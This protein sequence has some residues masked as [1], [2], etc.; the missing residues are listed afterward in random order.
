MGISFI[1][2]A[3]IHLGSPLVASSEEKQK[4][5]NSAIEESLN[6][7]VE[8][9]IDNSVDFVVIAGD[10]FD[11]SITN[12]SLA[13][14]FIKIMQPLTNHKIPSY[15]IWGNHDAEGKHNL[16]FSDSEYIHFFKASSPH[17]FLINEKHIALHGQSFASQVVKEN[18]AIN[19]P[20]KIEGA[21]NIGVL[22]TSLDGR[23]GH[24]TYAPCSLQDLKNKEYD[25]WALGHIHKREI[26]NDHR[27]TV[28]YSGNLQGR[29]IKEDNDKGCYLVNI[30]EKHNVDA[31]FIPISK[32]IFLREEINLEN[33]KNKDEVIQLVRE[34][35]ALNS[36]PAYLRLTF[37]GK[38]I[39]SSSL[40]NNNMIETLRFELL[41][42]NIT[43]MKIKNAT[44]YPKTIDEVRQGKN[45]IGNMLSLLSDETTKKETL[46]IVSEELSLF[47]GISDYLPDED[48]LYFRLKENSEET[49]E[50]LIV[51]QLQKDLV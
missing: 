31:Q 28:I 3:D 45:T 4:E 49:I 43:L 7:V 29:H 44:T 33:I 41:T 25:Y 47:K 21:Y 1:H 17:T 51:T 13:A 50:N 18:L 36:K 10:L 12:A 46:D 14:K 37:S 35:F 30:D 26:V 5:I 32:V 24:D 40:E 20:K 48:S 11:G 39:L 42:K 38:T 8:L 22:H 19:Y 16:S 23:E 6:K 2:V 27:P 9:A 15:I 34:H